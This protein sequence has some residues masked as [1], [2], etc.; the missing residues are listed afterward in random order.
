MDEQVVRAPTHPTSACTYGLQDHGKQEKKAKS[1]FGD[2]IDLL[3]AHVLA[4][5]LARY[6]GKGPSATQHIGHGGST[7]LATVEGR[8]IYVMKG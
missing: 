7:S 1:F 6:D 2:Q 4:S 8:L 5:F 3:L